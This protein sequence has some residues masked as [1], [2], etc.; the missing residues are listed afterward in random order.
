MRLLIDME[1]IEYTVAGSRIG[2]VLQ[3]NWHIGP[4]TWT[5]S[6]EQSKLR[7][8]V[9][10]FATLNVRGLYRTG[11]LIILEKEDGLIWFGIGPSGRIF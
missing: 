1:N 5:D 4:W 2:V 6:L 11:S 8:M 9:M 10:R 7:N 3:Q